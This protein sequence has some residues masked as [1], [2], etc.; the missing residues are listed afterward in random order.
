MKVQFLYPRWGAEAIPWPAFL[1]SI[2]SEGFAGVEWNPDGAP[3]TER[4]AVM[5]LLKQMQLDYAI[6]TTVAA[7]YT[8]FKEYMTQ[9][10]TLLEQLTDAQAFVLQPL[11][12]TMQTG[13]EFFTDAQILRCDELMGSFQQK[14]GIPIYHETHRNKWAY[15]VH[16][17]PP[18]IEKCAGIGLTLDVSHWFCV[19]EGYLPDQ[20]A[21]VSMAIEQAHHIHARVGF[22]QGPQVSDPALSEYEQALNEHLKIWDH[23]L[24]RRRDKGYE[25]STITPEFGPPPYMVTK[26]EN[27]QEEQWRLNLWMKNLLSER[28][29]VYCELPAIEGLRRNG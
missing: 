13:R 14:K 24:A 27:P 3:A 8:G 11:F 5:G 2:K 9:L 17:L 1:A 18:I 12:I 19:S 16:R 23:W 20:Q 4:D 7:P 25:V 26:A 6:V 21:A 22:D 15:A 10:N 29:G 28:Y